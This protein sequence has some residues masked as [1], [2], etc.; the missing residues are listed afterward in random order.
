LHLSSSVVSESLKQGANRETG[1]DFSLHYAGIHL[2]EDRDT[3]FAA[4]A[5]KSEKKFWNMIRVRVPLGLLTSE[6]Y[7]ALDALAEQSTYNRSLRFTTGQSVQLHG[8]DERDLQAVQAAITEAGLAPGCHSSGLEF[9]IAVPPSPIE[10]EPYIRLR[11]LAAEL[12]DEFYPR[13]GERNE[14]FPNHSPRKFAIGLGLTEDN[15]VNV[16]ANDVGLLLLD[17]PDGRPWLN[18]YAGG[19]LSMP[20][21]RPDTYARIASPLGSVRSSDCVEVVRAIATVFKKFGELPTR[22]YTR[23]KYVVDELGIERFTREVEQELGKDFEPL[24]SHGELE[25]RG[26]SGL[27]DQ[28][29]GEFYYGLRVPFGR[30]IDSGIARY[31]SAIR[32]IVETFRP[33]IVISPDQNLIFAGLRIEQIEPL[34]RILKAYHVPH[35]DEIT[36]F[37]FSAMACAGLPTCPMALAESERVAPE[38]IRELEAILRRI[39]KSGVPFSFRISGCPIGCIRPN[40]VDLGVIGR[41]PGHYDLYIGG[42]E[43]SVRFGDLY[44]ESVPLEEIVSTVKPLL[45]FWGEYSQ[46]DEPFSDFY[47]RWFGR[48]EAKDRLVAREQSIRDLL[49]REMAGSSGRVMAGR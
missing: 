48:G 47:A 41:K 35:G 17:A 5:A 28:H 19:S 39:G 29:N 18:V 15:S 42:S 20:T 33:R 31:K 37:K 2:Q 38:V 1:K 30:I 14:Y 44:A 4:N 43:S 24:I 10:T 25:V 49:E 27:H 21:R 9:A 34:E 6:Q 23:L 3:R 46:A 8:I 32:L 13:P 16:F 36:P 40:M 45:E 12:A 26:W 7:L 11:S 22:R